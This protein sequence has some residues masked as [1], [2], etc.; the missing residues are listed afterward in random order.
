MIV[1]AVGLFLATFYFAGGRIVL[2]PQN[3]PFYLIIPAFIA[4]LYEYLW[5][6]AGCDSPGMLWTGIRVVDFDGRKPDLWQRA[7]RLVGLGLGLCAAGV[8]LVWSLVD[9]ESLTWHDH[10]SRTFPTVRQRKGEA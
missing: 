1:I 7:M 9:E 4:F 3:L 10:M 6:V 5:C 8:G 2:T